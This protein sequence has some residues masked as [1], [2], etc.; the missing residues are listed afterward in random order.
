LKMYAS[1]KTSRIRYVRKL[2][3]A[4]TVLEPRVRRPLH[5]LS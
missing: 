3:S 1:A 5:I 4:S 2:G